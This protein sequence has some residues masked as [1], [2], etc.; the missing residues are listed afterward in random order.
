MAFNVSILHP[1][2][3]FKTAR[4]GG[5]GGQNVNKVETKV[6][7]YFNVKNT[8]SLTDDQKNLILQKLKNRINSEGRLMISC[9]TARSQFANKKKAIQR[10]DELLTKAL[11]KKKK[12]IPTALTAAQKAKRLQLK[13]RHS[14]KKEMRKGSFD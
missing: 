11:E 3:D 7:L 12:R 14:E 1:E 2:L 8:S 9:Q 13:K 10:F 5:K 4:S 6:E